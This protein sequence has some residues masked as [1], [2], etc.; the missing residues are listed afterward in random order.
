MWSAISQ[1]RMEDTPAALEGLGKLARA[2]WRPLYIFLRQRGRD[3]EHASDD[4]QG[5]FADLLSREFLSY[6]RPESGRFRSVLLASLQRWLGKQA[7]HAN[8]LKRGGG[9]ERVALDFGEENTGFP[10]L[11]AE[12]DPG[13]AFD[14]QWALDVVDRAVLRLQAAY[15]ER[16]RGGTFAALRGALPGGAALPAYEVLA[17]QT[18]MA[19]P[20]LRKAV[21][22]LRARFAGAIRQ[23]IACT[24]SD[25][26]EVE[27]EVRYLAR[28]LRG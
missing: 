19:E 8:R 6:A 23:E 28:L 16:S 7:D 4:V 15:A 1:A 27:D 5:F 21:H 12:E 17:E 14:R 18:G 2:Y 24:V 11:L 10:E 26:A 3:H 22:D 25:P 20:A 9:W 13:R